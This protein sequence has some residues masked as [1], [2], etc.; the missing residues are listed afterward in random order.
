MASKAERDAVK[1]V[2]LAQRIRLNVKDWY[3]DAQ[4][5]DEMKRRARDLWDEAR[6][7]GVEADVTAIV[8]PPL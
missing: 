2:R 1:A 8:C 4:D 5:F 7:E 3:D 6:R